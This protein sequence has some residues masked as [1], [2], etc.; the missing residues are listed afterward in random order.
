MMAFAERTLESHGC[1][2]ATSSLDVRSALTQ[3]VSETRARISEDFRQAPSA[4]QPALRRI[5]EK[6]LDPSFLARK[7]GAELGARGSASFRRALERSPKSYLTEA[8]LEVAARLLSATDCS[9]TAIGSWVGFQNPPAFFEAFKCWCGLTPAE[10]RRGVREKDVPSP[11]LLS[12]RFWQELSRGNDPRGSHRLASRLRER[13]GLSGRRR[14]GVTDSGID[15]WQR[16]FISETC[17]RLVACAPDRRSELLASLR[18][19]APEIVVRTFCERS[20]EEGRQ[21]RRRGIEIAALALEV[22]QQSTRSGDEDLKGLRAYGWAVLGNAHRLAGELGAAEKAFRKSRRELDASPSPV[23]AG[24]LVEILGYEGALRRQQ[25]RLGRALALLDR[26]IALGWTLDERTPLIKALLQRVAVAGYDGRPE[27]TIPD[28]LQVLD[29]LK[30]VDQPLLETMAY[31]NLAVSYVLS[32][33]FRTAAEIFPKAQAL[34]EVH[35]SPLLRFQLETIEG[36]IRQGLGELA[37][38]AEILSRARDG[39]ISLGERDHAA[40][41]SMELAVVRF[42]QDRFAEAARLAAEAIPLFA[43]VQAGRDAAAAREVLRQALSRQCLTEQALL[44]A[45]SCL[46]R[47]SRD[48]AG[49]FG[50]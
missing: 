36:L 50:R 12:A 27:E 20:L 10:F 31:Q 46:R 49:R 32:G 7:L 18:F 38:A 16:R 1:I 34:G 24:L 33:S 47:L 17:A 22:L 8:R 28:L 14:S 26:A 29:L 2:A 3:A 21:D 4:L 11:A 25:R 37:A 41:A 40:A 43:S 39:L 23:E 15:S 45:R 35:G 44:Q 19:D 30:D 48:P 9:G 13:Y 6:L 5:E 42:R